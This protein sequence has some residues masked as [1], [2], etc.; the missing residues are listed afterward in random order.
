MSKF[1]IGNPPRDWQGA[2]AVSLKLKRN[3]KRL[4]LKQ[5]TEQLGYKSIEE[6]CK[7]IPLEDLNKY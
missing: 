3:K 4:S 5:L 7:M 2:K 6:M 1:N